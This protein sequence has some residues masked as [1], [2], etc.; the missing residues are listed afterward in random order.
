MVIPKTHNT[1]QYVLFTRRVILQTFH[2]IP[3]THDV[4][5]RFRFTSK[6]V[7]QEYA[8]FN[9]DGMDGVFIE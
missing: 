3:E 8:G 4:Y 1:K 9:Q 5:R 7:E 2:V 6:A